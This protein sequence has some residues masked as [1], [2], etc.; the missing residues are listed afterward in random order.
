M[1]NSIFGKTMENARNYRDI[2]IVTTDKQQYKLASQSNYHSTKRISKNLSIMKM[3]KVSVKMSKAIYLGQ[4]ILDISKTL[5]HEFWYQYIKLKY[6]DKARLCYMDTDSFI[7]YIKTEDFYKDISN[8]IDKWFD[9]SAYDKNYNRPLPIGINKKIIGKFKDELNGKI[10]TELLAL[11]AKAY[12][13]LLDDDSK[14]KNAKGT[15]KCVLKHKRTFENYRE[16]LFNNKITIKSQQR[17]RS[18]H[19]GVYTDEFNKTALS[20]NDD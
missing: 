4:A 13:F 11:R 1:N 7:I 10:M 5:M 19:H 15:K 2:R 12:A 6:K 18:N 9:T 20:S 8:D 16:S 3:K 14:H 17:F